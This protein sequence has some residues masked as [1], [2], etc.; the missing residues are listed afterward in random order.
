MRRFLTLATVVILGAS[1]A[2]GQYNPSAT[3]KPSWGVAPGVI[4]V[5]L[6]P[7]REPARARGVDGIPVTGFPVVDAV[8]ET[9][10]GRSFERVFAGRERP[11][12]G[13]GLHDLT[14]FYRLEFDAVRD[15]QLVAEEVANDPNVALA[16]VI[17]WNRMDQFIPNDARF[18]DLWYH[19]QTADHDMDTP[20]AWTTQSGDPDVVVA[21]FDTGILYTHPDLMSQIWVNPGE[22]LDGDGVV[23]DADDMNGVDDDGNGFIDDVIGWDF[24]EGGSSC[25]PGEDCFGRDND[26]KDF[27][28]HGSHVAGIVGA[29]VNN[30]R[31]VAGVAGGHYPD[32]RGALLMPVRIGY[33]FNDGGFENGATRMDYV[34]AALDYAVMMGVKV[35]NLS[36][37]SSYNAA[38]DAALAN[39]FA[40]GF[41]FTKSAGN[42]N[43]SVADFVDD[44]PGVIAVA[45]TNAND[46]K[47]SFS[48][49][50]PWVDVTA[51]GVN[52]L[53]TFS[54]HY[55]PALALLQGTSMA[56]PMVAGIA[57]LIYS[58]SPY[59]TKAEVDSI[60]I[61]TTDYIYGQNPGW[62]GLL[63]TGRVNA[64]NAL[65]NLPVADFTSDVRV[66]HVPLAVQFTDLS[67]SS[68]TGWVWDFGDA[69]SATTQNPLHTY[70]STGLY[71]VRFDAVTPT[72]TAR[73]HRENYIVVQADT[74]WSIHGKNCPGRKAELVLQ[75]TNALPVY[76]L[77]LPLIYDGPAGLVL[78]SFS[79]AGTRVEY[80][81]KLDRPFSSIP[82]KFSVFQLEA[83][84][85][86]GS[87]PLPP[88]SGPLMK[89][90]MS[91]DAGATP[92]TFAIVDTFTV[93]GYNYT[94][95]ATTTHGVE[96]VPVYTS[97]GI[98]VLTYCRGDF[99]LNGAVNSADI[100]SMVG[101]VFKGGTASDDP[102]TMDANTDGSV[103]SADIIF[104]VN[105]V[106]KS[107]PP[108]E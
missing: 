91:I 25:W 10:R 17:T 15:P 37:G 60:I 18:D 36:Y 72:G 106:F 12:P 33:S 80:F 43:Q 69:D 73:R 92:G 57:A 1:A 42:D 8:S 50:G 98:D 27:N 70:T 88:G 107:G 14:R 51:P 104:L 35:G 19:L 62:E 32:E 90:Y 65:A 100:L 2:W 39:A 5:Q 103:T 55:A 85:G 48:D 24:V 82:N 102:W 53:S 23:Y 96:Y 31:D 97:V 38:L 4:L 83:D 16:E 58:N 77:D 84:N 61:N 94:Y 45:A 11:E 93:P 101:Y 54:N 13:S 99:D 87:P 63:G 7:D 76:N 9:L 68:P 95:R 34:A 40:N 75:L 105:Y 26:P 108:P 46:Q 22:D 3:A 21:I 41:I 20:E 29:A 67:P 78:D 47:A 44:Y 30:S 6:K 89:L 52:I 79:F 49:W 56:A 74:T 59:L 86:G 81:E 28:G 66:G 64:A 71:D